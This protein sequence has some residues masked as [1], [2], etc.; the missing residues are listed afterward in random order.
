MTIRRC[1]NV[2]CNDVMACN[3]NV[4]VLYGGGGINSMF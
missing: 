1:T 4:V 3:T 2:L